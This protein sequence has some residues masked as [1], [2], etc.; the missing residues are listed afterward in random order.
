MDIYHYFDYQNTG[1]FPHWP[2]NANPFLLRPHTSCFVDIV[3][4]NQALSTY[5]AVTKDEKSLN[6]K[7]MII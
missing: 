1:L 5:Y 3:Y 2:I 4:P 6:E 7:K